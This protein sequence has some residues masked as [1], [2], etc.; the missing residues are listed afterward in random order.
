M[1]KFRAEFGELA[2]KEEE[3]KEPAEEAPKK[4]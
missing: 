4:E 1:G 2:E 3:K